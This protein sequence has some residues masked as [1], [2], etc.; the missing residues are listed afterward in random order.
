[1]ARRRD[2]LKA[3]VRKYFG[4]KNIKSWEGYTKTLPLEKNWDDAIEEYRGKEERREQSAE[5]YRSLGGK[6]VS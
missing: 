2:K 4:F 5:E 6:K 3:D 1:M